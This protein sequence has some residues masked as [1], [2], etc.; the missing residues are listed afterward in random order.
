MLAGVPVAGMPGAAAAGADSGACCCCCTPPGAGRAPGVLL[1][2]GAA[3]PGS[4]CSIWLL[5]GGSI[6]L[7][8]GRDPTGACW[9]ATA[10]GGSCRCWARCCSRA[11]CC[12]KAICCC[13]KRCWCSAVKFHC[14]PGSLIPAAAD[15]P[16]S[17]KRGQRLPCSVLGAGVCC[18]CWP[19]TDVHEAASCAPATAERHRETRCHA[20]LASTAC[21]QRHALTGQ[22]LCQHLN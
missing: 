1:A 12:W 4:W 9:L 21:A 14:W 8:P 22:S 11:C 7:G 15:W 20:A 6:E 10:W 17:H 18:N 2:G 3:E 16:A 19:A 13:R 5:T